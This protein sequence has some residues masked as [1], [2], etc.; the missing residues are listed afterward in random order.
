MSDIYTFCTACNFR[1]YGSM[2]PRYGPLRK[3]WSSLSAA[4]KGFGVVFDRLFHVPRGISAFIQR[5]E[6]ARAPV[7]H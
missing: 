2:S 1:K 5:S 4:G 7:S 3:G 6:S